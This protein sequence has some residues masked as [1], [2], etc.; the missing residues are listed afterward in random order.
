MFPLQVQDQDLDSG[1]T[2]PA[3][4]IIYI[5]IHLRMSRD[6]ESVRPC[7][8]ASVRPCVRAS[9]RPCGRAAVRSCLIQFALGSLTLTVPINH[10]IM[11]VYCDRNYIQVD[12][13]T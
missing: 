13:I 12:T 9:V 4:H 1:P 7:V 6:G 10:Y 11:K 8:R 2:L 5:Y 3:D